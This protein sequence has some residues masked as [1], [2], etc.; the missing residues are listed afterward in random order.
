[1]ASYNA[2]E[3]YQTTILRQLTAP[4]KRVG[5]TVTQEVVYMHDTCLEFDDEHLEYYNYNAHDCKIIEASK[6]KAL[7][8]NRS[9]EIY[10]YIY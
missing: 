4:A 3:D 8:V 7:K 6:L 2:N 10:I 1:M 5:I 9:K